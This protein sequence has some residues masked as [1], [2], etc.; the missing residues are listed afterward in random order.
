MLFEQCN[1]Y[2]K[3]LYQF[4]QPIYVCLQHVI[5]EGDAENMHQ[6]ENLD[7]IILKIAQL[8]VQYL[9]RVLSLL[10]CILHQI[11]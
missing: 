11:V 2:L 8:L 5:D 7:W 4:F 1:L 6:S 3:I 9:N 10:H